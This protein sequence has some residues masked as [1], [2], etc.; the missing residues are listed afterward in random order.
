MTLRQNFHS[1]TGN[2]TALVQQCKES[3]LLSKIN[4]IK[5]PNSYAGMWES[6]ILSVDMRMVY[7]FVTL[8]TAKGCLTSLHRE[9]AGK[10]CT[11]NEV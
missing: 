3:Q 5:K 4:P 8:R 2:V 6:V 1:G 10:M 11:D 9:I 7:I